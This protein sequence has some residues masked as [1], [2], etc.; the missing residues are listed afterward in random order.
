L[1][2]EK[3][4]KAIPEWKKM[5]SGDTIFVSPDEGIGFWSIHVNNGDA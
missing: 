2:K 4:V 5:F 1:I 3:K